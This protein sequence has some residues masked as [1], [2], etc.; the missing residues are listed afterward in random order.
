MTNLEIIAAVLFWIAC[1]AFGAFIIA[2]DQKRLIATDLMFVILMGPLAAI[3][4][5]IGILISR[6][7]STDT[8][9]IWE[10]KER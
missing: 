6:A 9:V 7:Y 5:P 10:K 4:L 3:A 1:A 8:I 2:I